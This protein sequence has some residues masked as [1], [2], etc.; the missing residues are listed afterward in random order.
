MTGGGTNGVG[1]TTGWVE[2]LP[3]FI[4]ANRVTTLLDEPGVRLLDVRESWEYEGIGH[5]PGAVNI[6]FDRF[7]DAGP[8][9]AG[10]LPG[11]TV[12]G[13]LLG[14]VGVNADDALIVYDDEHGVY[15]SRVAVTARLYGHDDAHVLDGDYSAWSLCHRTSLEPVSPDPVDYTTPTDVDRPLVDADGVRAATEHPETAVVDTRTKQEFAEGHV[16][17]ATQLDWRDLVDPETR[18]LRAVDDLLAVLAEKDLDPTSPVVLYCNT[19][20]RLSHTYLV[21]LQ[22]DFEDVRFYEGSLTDWR[23]RGLELVTGD[24]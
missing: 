12:L 17:G 23:E 22:L 13:D 21:L 5:L 3:P 14:G 2:G 1:G 16:R 4:E 19:A 6:P 15:A 20:R 8:A 18:G 9:D 11:A 7:R 24:G 10:M